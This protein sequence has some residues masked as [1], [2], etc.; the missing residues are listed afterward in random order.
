MATKTIK[1]SSNPGDIRIS[2]VIISG[3]T[4]EEKNTRKNPLLPYR[5]FNYDR[6]GVPGG[7]FPWHWHDEVECFSIRNGTMY[8]GIPGEEV[9][10]HEGDVGF[11]NS[12]VLHMTQGAN[13]YPF[14]MQNHI[15][16]P[17]LIC[18]DRNSPLGRKYVMPLLS[19]KCARL[20]RIEADNPLAAEI[21]NRMEDANS[22]RTEAAAGYEL[23]IRNCMSDIWLAFLRIMPPSDGKTDSVDSDR[24][25]VMLT[26]IQ[27]NY[28]RKISLEEIA[29]AAHISAKE[30]ER[31]FR[32]QIRTLPFDYLMDYRLERAREFLQNGKMSVTEIAMRCGFGSTSYFG[33]CFRQKYGISPRQYRKALA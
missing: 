15:F 14:T 29:G 25:M 16:S 28:D 6:Q 12:G 2:D 7:I 8:Y 20:L 9:I 21:R 17:D 22:A 23:T 11:L 31:C 1:I 18:G 19:N 27:E 26:W 33:S 24:L 3:A 13:A 5:G 32:R 4:Q 10:F 30:C